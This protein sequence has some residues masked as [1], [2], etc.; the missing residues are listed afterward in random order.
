MDELSED[1]GRMLK[2]FTPQQVKAALVQKGIKFNQQIP[3]VGN[4]GKWRGLYNFFRVRYPQNIPVTYSYLR[5]DVQLGQTQTISFAINETDNSIPK[6]ITER[7][8]KLNDTFECVDVALLLYTNDAATIATLPLSTS[9]LLTYD[10]PFV[11][12]TTNEAERLYAIYNVGQLKFKL[13]NETLFDGIACRDFYRVPTSQAGLAVSAVYNGVAPVVT[14][15][16][17]RDGY[18]NEGWPFMDLSPSLTLSGN[19]ANSFTIELPESVNFAPSS[20]TRKNY[21]SLI[22]RG[23]QAQGGTSQSNRKV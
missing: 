17:S 2:R 9:R 6:L 4:S 13:S 10:N 14:G 12:D 3:P 15:R 21:A 23:Y 22:I 1:L 16:I 19:G 18:N 5:A 11:F 20:G 7:R 8:L